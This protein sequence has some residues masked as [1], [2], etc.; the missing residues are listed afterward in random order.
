VKSPV[1]T[2]IKKKVNTESDERVEERVRN[3]NLKDMELFLKK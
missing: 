2:P 3:E 1:F